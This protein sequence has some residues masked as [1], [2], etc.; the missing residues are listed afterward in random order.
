M[1]QPNH[2]KDMEAINIVVEESGKISFNTQEIEWKPTC[3]K[4]YINT[5][6]A[7]LIAK[8][9][10]PNVKSDGYKTDAEWW[11]I[12]PAGMMTIYNYKDGTNY[13]GAEGL[14]VSEI[15]DWHVGGEVNVEAEEVLKWINKI[16]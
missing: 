13:L 4:G 9:G 16:I 11:L 6:Y 12:T 7:N 10:Q 15:T 8:L 1:V 14:K 3:L 2:I 5:T